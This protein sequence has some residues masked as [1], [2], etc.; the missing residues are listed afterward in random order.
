[1][2][3]KLIPNFKN[4]KEREAFWYQ[5]Y[6]EWK[7]SGLYKI[8]FCSKHNISIS[9][10]YRWERYFN[11]SSSKL[12]PSKV[13]QKQ[14]VQNNRNKK[15]T[16]IPVEI[17]DPIKKDGLKNYCGPTNKAYYAELIFSNGNRIVFNQEI[18]INLLSQLI[19]S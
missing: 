14:L 8:D 3:N 7:T 4:T 5:I 17:I 13:A 19:L 18:N 10:L 2:I 9:G 11:K 1:M 6:Q 16:F 12:E 15:A